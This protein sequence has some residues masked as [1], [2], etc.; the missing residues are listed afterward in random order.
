M[1]DNRSNPSVR[2]DRENPEL[3]GYTHQTLLPGV[4]RLMLTRPCPDNEAGEFFMV[5]EAQVVEREGASG[6]YLA[7]LVI[8]GDHR[9][10]A[11]FWT[12]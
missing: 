11:E 10:M 9:D 12:A 1:A 4:N 5:G 2:G 8:T 6:S 7:W 3:I